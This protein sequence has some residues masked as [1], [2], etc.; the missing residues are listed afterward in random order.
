M[1]CKTST[2][3]RLRQERAGGGIQNQVYKAF[4]EN[5]LTANEIRALHQKRTNVI[6]DLKRDGE[7]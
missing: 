5:M 6:D 3:L 2:A 7:L 1:G 4:K